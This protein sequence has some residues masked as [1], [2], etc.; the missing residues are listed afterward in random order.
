M[1]CYNSTVVN[2]PAEQVW[3]KLRNFHDMSW[4]KGVIETCTPAGSKGPTEPGAQRVLNGAFHETLKGL[5][6]DSRSL[7]YSIDAGP[8]AVSKDNV[9]GYIGEVRVFPVTDAN[10]TFVLW[11]SQWESS[12]GGVAEFCDPI[13]QG[14]LS[15]L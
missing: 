10:A 6:D 5:D 1:A 11:T 12:G 7:H 14:L 3:E 15:A 2:A 9:Q 8:A 13:Y 4:A